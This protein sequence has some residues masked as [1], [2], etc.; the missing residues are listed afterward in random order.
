MRNRGGGREANSTTGRSLQIR[1]INTHHKYTTIGAIQADVE[2]LWAAGEGTQSRGQPPLR[3]RQQRGQPP[4]LLL[5]SVQ[6]PYYKKKITTPHPELI[7]V[8][9]QV[10]NGYKIRALFYISKKINFWLFT[11]FTDPD[12]VTIGLKIGDRNIICINI[13][14]P[15]DI[16]RHP[17]SLTLHRAIKFAK[18][19]GWGIIICADTNSHHPR[20]GSTNLNKRG[21][22]LYE[23][24]TYHD[25]NICNV[26]NTPTFRC[27]DRLE[28]LDITLASNNILH[29][30]EGWKVDMNID[31][32]SDH[33]LITFT[34]GGG[35]GRGNVQKTNEKI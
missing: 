5:Y 24:I 26:G 13:Y 11:Q 31:M 4:P 10:G 25:L 8:H 21:E 32:D 3:P 17:A 14:C 33:N 28:V 29:M 16:K 27:A 35:G 18:Q 20:W 12:C 2:E 6:E 34:L 7:P 1:Q 30:V 23:F 15:Y 19:K 9:H 22:Y